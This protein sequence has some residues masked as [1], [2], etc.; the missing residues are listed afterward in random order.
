MSTF[1]EQALVKQTVTY[2]DVVAAA[3]LV[4]D[5]GLTIEQEIRLVWP[6]PFNAGKALYFLTRYPPFADTFMVLYHQFAIMSPTT[7]SGI[8]KA[9]GYM[10]GFGTL[11]AESILALRTW[12]IWRR[13]M[14]IAF[15]LGLGLVLFWVPVFYFDA[16]ALNS[17]VFTT[18][19]QPNLPGCYVATQKNVLFVVFVMIMVFE[20]LILIL[21]LVKGIDHFRRTTSSLVTVLYRDGLTFYI[22]LFVLS[23]INVAVLL[24]APHGYSTL[25]TAL[26]RVLHSIFSARI[27]LHLRQAATNRNKSLFQSTLTRTAENANGVFS[28]QRANKIAAALETTTWFGDGREAYESFSSGH[29]DDAG[30]A[31]EVELPESQS[32]PH[33]DDEE[34]SVRHSEG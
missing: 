2:L 34:R 21:T 13:D 29:P 4:F 27:L 31:V 33:V 7:C 3:L 8:Y 11:V 10:L 18:P 32:T 28:Q 14:R 5:Y 23:I 25:L 20:T 17:I 19:P 30:D 12:V 16:Q 6:T 22:Y 24:N 9:I 15:G 26:Q 1:A